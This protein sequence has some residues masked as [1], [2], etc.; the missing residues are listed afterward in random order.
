MQKY[1]QNQILNAFSLRNYT[2]TVCFHIGVSMQINILVYNYL[3]VTYIIVFK[4]EICF[5][6]QFFYLYPQLGVLS[7]KLFIIN[8]ETTQ[9]GSENGEKKINKNF[10]LK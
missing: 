2:D 6:L 7:W 8:T 9:R 4:P 1:C 10:T 5:W 3:S